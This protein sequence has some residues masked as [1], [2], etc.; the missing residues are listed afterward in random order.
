MKADDPGDPRAAA[1]PG[2]V[3]VE[4][5]VTHATDAPVAA[6]RGGG[7]VR[8]ALAQSVELFPASDGDVYLLRAGAG[9]S[10]AIRKPTD[11]DRQLLEALRDGV[12]IEP[13]TEAY[14]RLEPLVDAG[15]AVPSPMPALPDVTAERFDRQLRYLTELGDPTELMSRLRSAH[16]VVI[17]CGGLGTWALAA[18]AAAGIGRYTLVDDDTVERSNLNRQVLYGE[19]D[20][21]RPK[22]D[23]AADWLR[24]FDAELRVVAVRRRIGCAADLDDFLADAH[25]L[26]LTADWPPYDLGRW[27]NACCVERGIPFVLAAQHPPL[28]KVGPTYWPGRGPCFSCHERSAAKAFPLYDEVVA[29]RRLRP[30]RSSTLGPSSGVVSTLLS[31]DAMHLLL[32]RPPSTL[33]RALLIDMSSLNTRWEAIERDPSCPACRSL[34]AE[35]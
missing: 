5:R 21:G 25:L 3:G 35:S 14:R 13:S 1:R 2:L 16:V 9:V 11:E 22:V 19:A 31:L 29:H 17:G 20:V 33:G 10:A 18:L 30:S 23:C 24:A 7:A 26:V 8:Y 4:G 28:L 6:T 27:A 32:G 15:L 12:D 34:W